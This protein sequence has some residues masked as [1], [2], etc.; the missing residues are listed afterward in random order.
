MILN[1]KSTNVN[2]EVSNQSPAISFINKPTKITGDINCNEDLRIAGT[3]EGEVHS[4]MKFIL[5]DSGIINGKVHSQEA[6]IAGTVNGDVR[7]KD[8]LTLKSTAVIEGKIYTKK[9]S[10]ED[11]AQIKGS[12]HVGPNVS[13]EDT[14]S[15]PTSKTTSSS[16][17]DSSDKEK[18]KDE[19]SGSGKIFSKN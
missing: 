9:I 7:V 12:L 14:S 18:S 15:T 3:I 4:K 10:I 5:N 1:R 16:S 2:T 11:G 6:E 8:K 17:S 13:I 19:K